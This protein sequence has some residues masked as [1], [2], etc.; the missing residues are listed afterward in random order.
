MQQRRCKGCRV[1]HPTSR[2]GGN[3]Q[4]LYCIACRK[5]QGEQ[6]LRLLGKSNIEIARE[7]RLS[8]KTVGRWLDYARKQLGIHSRTLLAFYALGKG[9]VSQAEIKAA[10]KEQEIQGKKICH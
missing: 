5:R 10:I 6:I 9:M 3:H 1:I 4:A 2:F 8:R 7:L